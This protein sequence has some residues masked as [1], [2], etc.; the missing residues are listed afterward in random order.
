MHKKLWYE[1]GLK[2]EYIGTNN[3]RK[4]EFNPGL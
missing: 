4:E 3:V 2:L 1:G